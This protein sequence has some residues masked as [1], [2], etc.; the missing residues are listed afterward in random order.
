MYVAGGS[1]RAITAATSVF[2][3]AVLLRTKVRNNVA[4]I[5]K[6]YCNWRDLPLPFTVWAAQALFI[7]PISV[8]KWLTW[9]THCKGTLLLENSRQI[10]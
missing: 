1:Y 9:K 5:A 8:K 2:T 10:N 6:G 7:V 3:P 4:E